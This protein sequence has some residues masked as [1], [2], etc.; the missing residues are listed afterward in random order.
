MERVEE[1]R[2]ENAQLHEAVRSHAVVDQAIG[3]VIVLGRLTP[4]QGWDVLRE[5]SQ[6]TNSKL[7][8]VAQHL[9][10]WARTGQLDPDLHK[11]LQQQ[12]DRERPPH[13]QG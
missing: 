6:R 2:D 9:V 5:I 8:H 7:R 13:P 12:L 10:D 1:L 11:E 4:E 3:V